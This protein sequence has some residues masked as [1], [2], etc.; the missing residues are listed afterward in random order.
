VRSGNTFTGFSSAD[1]TTWTQVGTISV[2]MSGN[3]A[4]G[5]AVCAHNNAAV[6][7]STFDSVSITAPV[8]TPDFT[9][10]ASP[11]P[12]TIT[13][14]GSANYTVTVGAMNGFTGNVALAVSGP[15]AVSASLNSASINTS[16]TATLSAGSS[17]AGTYSLAITA[18]SGSLSHSTTVTLQVNS[19]CM[20]AGTTWQNVSFPTQTGTFT[21]TFDG[22][23]SA[24]G[25]N[26]VMALSQGVPSPTTGYAGY[27][28]LAR[29]N[30]TNDIDARS[31]GS[32]NVPSPA[33]PYTA[34]HLYHFRLVINI[35]AHTYSAFVTPADGMEQTIGTSLGFRTEQ[36]GVTSLDNFG[37]YAASGSNSVCNFAIQ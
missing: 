26:S 27:A 10:S 22:T 2:T 28:T 21:A 9:L 18:T 5:L 25:M 23:P 29:F 12:Q 1:G 37:V 17:T 7:T 24:A 19:T 35:P 15:A 30:S 36:I 13:T 14:G 20:T 32:Y 34:G 33:I 6:S 4:A 8:S 31:G 16:G 11:S 3:V